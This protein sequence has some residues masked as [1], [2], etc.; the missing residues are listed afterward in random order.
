MIP[1][2]TYDLLLFII[3]PYLVSEIML[4][5]ENLQWSFQLIT[6]EI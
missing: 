1:V 2:T 3:L 6:L 5:L 4:V